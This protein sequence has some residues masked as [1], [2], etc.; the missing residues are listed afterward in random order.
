MFIFLLSQAPPDSLA[1]SEL[2]WLLGVA[3][4]AL[5]T[6][7]GVLWK[8]IRDQEKKI[9]TLVEACLTALTENNFHL[10]SAPE[11][12]KQL[13]EKIEAEHKETRAK[14]QS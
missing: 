10:G 12:L 4:A 13:V 6:V 5:V 3:I 8:V 11:R 2:F 14:I 1:K 9:E 7:V